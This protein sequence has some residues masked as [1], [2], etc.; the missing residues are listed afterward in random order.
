MCS[1]RFTSADGFCSPGRTAVRNNFLF[2]P[3]EKPI[4]AQLWGKNPETIYETAKVAAGMGF[5]G[6]DINMGCP[7]RNVM[8]HGV[9]DG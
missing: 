8:A 4:I 7:D 5:A 2:T 6:I 9:E 3:E 1:S